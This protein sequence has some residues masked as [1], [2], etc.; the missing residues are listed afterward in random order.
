MRRTV[1]YRT[2]KRIKDMEYQ[3][4]VKECGHLWSGGRIDESALDEMQRPEESFWMGSDRL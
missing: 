1:R 2:P 3:L 4:L